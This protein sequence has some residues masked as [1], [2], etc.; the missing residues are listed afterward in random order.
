MNNKDENLKE[1]LNKF[2]AEA[3]AAKAKEDILRGEQIISDNPSPQPDEKLISEIKSRVSVELAKQDKRG[4]RTYLRTALAAAAAILIVS[5]L[6]VMYN[7]KTV[8]PT[9]GPIISQAGIEDSDFTAD[10]AEL[11]VLA[12]D[13]EALEDEILALRLGGNGTERMNA[14]EIEIELL[15]INEDFWKG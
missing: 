10:D 14:D 8:K 5:G 2:Y 12:A 1:L 15:E 13:I 7:H 6:I 3:E 11:A 4:V 9:G